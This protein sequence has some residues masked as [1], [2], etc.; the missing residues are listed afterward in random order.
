MGRR[1]KK[2][3]RNRNRLPK[4]R[5]NEQIRAPRVLVIGPDGKNLG[6]MSVREAMGIAEEHGLDVVEVSPNA[7]PPVVRIMDYGKYMYELKKKQKKKDKTP[8][9]KEIE[10]T[11]TIGDHDL[12]VK[13]KKAR[14][15]LEKGHKVKIEIR[16]RGR[17]MLHVDITHN[18]AEKVIAM[19]D[20]VAA[21][22][23]EPK[24]EGR[25]VHF[26]LKPRKK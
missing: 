23:V 1:R 6:V 9:M 8:E 13:L 20:D 24:Q 2:N 10:L 4:V 16:M 15:F 12:Q 18:L 17:Q 7:N 21:V 14:E 3:N 11:P 22:D 19:L 25:F 5:A 26:I